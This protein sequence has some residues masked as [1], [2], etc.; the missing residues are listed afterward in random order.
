MRIR[1]QPEVGRGPKNFAT[2]AA[3]LN[4]Q[5]LQVLPTFAVPTTSFSGGRKTPVTPFP[6]LHFS[7][8][9]TSP[10][11]SWFGK[12]KGLQVFPS[13]QK[14]LVSKSHPAITHTSLQHRPDNELYQAQ[15]WGLFCNLS[16]ILKV[17]SNMSP[18]QQ[19]CTYWSTHLTLSVWNLWAVQSQARAYTFLDKEILEH[20]T[21]LCW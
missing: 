20:N 11:K 1:I 17:L 16:S 15:N 5:Q 12:P 2:R 19:R 9:L 14:N 18:N 7:T 21:E 8:L 3:Q 6:E 13:S 4:K 10:R